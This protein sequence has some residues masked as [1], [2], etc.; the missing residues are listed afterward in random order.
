MTVLVAHVNHGNALR[1]E[2]RREKVAHL[3]VAEHFRNG[4]GV[5]AVL[6]GAEAAVPAQVRLLAVLVVLAV[7]LVMLLVV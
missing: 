3:A 2:E 4:G 6:V 7:R 5:D 1:D